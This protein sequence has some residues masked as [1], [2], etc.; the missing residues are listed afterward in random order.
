MALFGKKNQGGKDKDASQPEGFVPKPDKAQRWVAQ[1]S[2][3]ADTGNFT[4][5]LTCYASAVK[6]DPANLETHKRMFEAAIGHFSAGGK[7]ASRK[8]LK[9]VDGPHPS[10]KVAVAELAWMRDVN[11]Y[12]LAMKLLDASIKAEL[13]ELSGWLAPKAFNMLKKAKKQSKSEYVKARNLFAAANAWDEAFEAGQ[14]A[15]KL[16]PNDTNLV[17]ELKQ[18]TAQRAIIAG[19]YEKAASEKGAFRSAVRDIDEQQRLEDESSVTGGS[20]DDRAVEAARSQL[21][22]TPDSPESVNKLAKLLLRMNTPESRAEAVELYLDAHQR[23]GQYQFRMSAGDLRIADAEERLRTATQRAENPPDDVPAA[24]L[25]AERHQAS[26]AL[27]DL[28]QAEFTERSEKYPTDR[29]IK[30]QLGNIQFDRGDFEGAM[31]N[32]QDCK[33]E[34]KFRVHSAHR[35]GNCFAEEGWFKEAVSEYKEAQESIDAT[36]RDLELPIKYDMMVALISL[37]REQ[38]SRDLADEAADICSEIV[39]KNI[40]YRDIRDRRREIDELAKSMS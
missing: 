30:F 8:E 38:A 34:P 39:R 28:R 32:F 33:D 16:D 11:N 36:N 29:G 27:I 19:G 1:G 21:E 3:I 7:P 24:D 31:A 5:A 23:L 35:L 12:A 15:A 22:A 6:L 20:A 26:E 10:D 4:Y 18:L 25:E 14:I 2:Q 9:D 17:Q 13:E 37:A 40:K